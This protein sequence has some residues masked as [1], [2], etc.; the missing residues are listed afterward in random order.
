MARAISEAP[1]S[2]DRPVIQ[3]TAE[4][5]RRMETVLVRSEVFPGRLRLNDLRPDSSPRPPG[6]RPLEGDWDYG[7][8]LRLRADSVGDFISLETLRAQATGEEALKARMAGVAEDEG[9][10]L[11]RWG[12]LSVTT[13]KV[14]EE[15]GRG[16]F[17][18][19]DLVLKAILED[20][21]PDHKLKTR[22]ED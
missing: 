9:A 13:G 18:E 15:M 22:E 21:Y 12:R 4:I 7:L 5:Q 2:Q 20:N 17:S 1:P 16:E 6:D 19:T 14:V 10:V 8:V 3:S 11:L